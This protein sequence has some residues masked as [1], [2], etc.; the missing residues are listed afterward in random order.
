MVFHPKTFEDRRKEAGTVKCG[1]GTYLTVPVSGKNGERLII[2]N[3][4]HG[5]FFGKLLGG[6]FYNGKRPVN[7]VAVNEIARQKDV[8]SAEVVAVIKK[9]WWG[10]F[11]KADFISRE[12]P[13]AVD[14]IQWITESSLMF[15]QGLKKPVIHAIA[16]LLR[17]MHDAG[18]FHADLHLKNILI[19][20]ETNGE[21]RAYIIDLD[22]SVVTEKLDMDKRITNLLRLDRSVEKLRWLSGRTSTS[23]HQKMGFISQADK[24]RFF[25]SYMLCGNTP[26]KDW[27]KCIRQRRSRHAVHKLWWRILHIFRRIP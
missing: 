7:E 21:F 13:D 26:D 10:L 3:Y 23:L 2:R 15:V 24:I 18:I 17:N 8:P 5:G 6:I 22:K 20:R 1:R 12:I 16:G 9:R 19:K 4:R 25:R 11:Y 27:K 14:L